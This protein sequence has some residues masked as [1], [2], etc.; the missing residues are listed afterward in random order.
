[1]SR[2]ADAAALDTVLDTVLGAAV[3]AGVAAG[4]GDGGAGR[5]HPASIEAPR[6]VRQSEERS[7]LYIRSTRR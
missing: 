1:M 2:A 6:I 3:G 7:S 5:L 4:I